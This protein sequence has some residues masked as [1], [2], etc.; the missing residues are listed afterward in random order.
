MAP[1][2]GPKPQQGEN[3]ENLSDNGKPQEPPA[4]EPPAPSPSSSSVGDNLAQVRKPS[5]GTYPPPGSASRGHPPVLLPASSALSLTLS[6]PDH[7][8]LTLPSLRSRPSKT[9]QGMLFLSP[10]PCPAPEPTIRVLD[11]KTAIT[12]TAGANLVVYPF[13]DL[14]LWRFIHPISTPLPPPTEPGHSLH[15]LKSRSQTQHQDPPRL[16]AAKSIARRKLDPGGRIPL[17]RM[18]GMLQQKDPE[19]GT[20][21]KRERPVE[22]AG[23]A[24]RGFTGPSLPEKLPNAHGVGR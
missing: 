21:Q 12:T 3:R 22:P 5:P 13:G 14:P 23:S 15:R 2:T 18:Q 6:C 11:F 24:R 7:S 17:F 20:L 16:L 9:L 10:P 1:T 8:S 19:K 4:H